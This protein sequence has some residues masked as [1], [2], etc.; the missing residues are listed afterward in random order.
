ML[1]QTAGDE[2]PPFPPNSPTSSGSRRKSSVGLFRRNGS[3]SDGNGELPLS[4]NSAPGGCLLDIK[5][6]KS[7]SKST[8]CTPFTLNT[9]VNSLGGFSAI[10][11]AATIGMETLGYELDSLRPE[12][13]VVKHCG[14]SVTL[15][16]GENILSL[17]LIYESI[18][19]FDVAL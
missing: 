8:P 6:K 4:N 3:P 18:F 9:G 16:D 19:G 13:N 7:R 2:L 11:A 5:K 10:A 12:G 14:V 15:N 17:D 1:K